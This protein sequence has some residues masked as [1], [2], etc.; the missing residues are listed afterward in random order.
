MVLES[1]VDP[2]KVR[3]KP[4]LM[5]FDS[6]LLSSIALWASFLVF[7]Q[8]V[9]LLSVAFIV[10]AT[11]PVIHRVFVLEEA[12]DMEKP[13]SASDFISRH[14]DV[15]SIYVWFFIGLVVSYSFWY[16]ALPAADSPFCLGESCITIPGRSNAFDQQE[17]T[18]EGI[19]T[20]SESLS[21]K[22]TG[23]P[24]TQG[25]F[26]VYFTTIFSNNTLV[27]LLAVA[28]SFV[29]GAGALFLITWNASVIAVKLGQ[30]AIALLSHYSYLGPFSIIAAYLH[31]LFNALGFVPH[32]V[33]E[34]PGF[35]V[36]AIAGGIISVVVT[37]KGY[38]KNE[39]NVVAKDAFA[40]L[41]LAIVL[42]FLG[43]VIE[44]LLITA[45]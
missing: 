14:F 28:F 42:V 36:G 18:L 38:K 5:F 26:W 23:V 39:L 16:V 20:L 3:A 40:M 2:L 37:K 6:I 11:M 15:I 8:S 19:A 30:G 12:E 21:G 31:G 35:F 22:V 41:A 17:K 45:A 24:N 29:Y 4:S 1:I 32:G 10:I 34:L 9:S 25:D 43:A 33:F 27:L 13:P 44:A 7:P